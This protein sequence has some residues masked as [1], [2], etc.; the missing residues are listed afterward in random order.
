MMD[1]V[2]NDWDDSVSMRLACLAL[3]KGRLTDDLVTALA[4]RGTL[5]IDLALRGRLTQTADAVEISRG[6]SGFPPADK[7]IADG[8]SSL[9]EWL[10]CGPVD[11]YDLAAEHL[12]RGSW[13]LK[14]RLLLRRYEDHRTDRTIEDRR[15]MESPPGRDWKPTDAALVAIASVLGLARTGRS[16]P[17]ESLLE[18]TVDVRWLTEFVVDEVNQRVVL[19]RAVRWATS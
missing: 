14:R 3:H 11:Q 15:A 6:P 12:R 19:G 17:T 13:T 9:A 2:E 5:L 18:A 1:P 16:L 7:L 8:A 10:R 4:V